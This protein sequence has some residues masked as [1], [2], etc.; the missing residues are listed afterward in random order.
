M[1]MKPIGPVVLY[2]P[3][4]PGL[5]T[6]RV[7][8]LD[9]P[10]SPR[11]EDKESRMRSLRYSVAVLA[12]VVVVGPGSRAA[13]YTPRDLLKFRP[14]QPS[15]DYDTPADAAA[16]DACKVELVTDGQKR[17]VGY[18]LRDGQGK[19]LRRFVI[20]SGGKYLNQWS[21]FQDGFEVYRE[22]DL[23]GDRSLDECRWLN[24]GG[25]RIAVIK[26]G[27]VVSWKRLSAEEASKVLV[28]ALVSGDAGLLESLMATADELAGAGVPKEVVEKLSAA[29]ARRGEM[30]DALHK[31][32][33][34]WTAKT[35]WNRF[36]GTFPHVIPAD[37][38]GGVEQDLVLYENAVIFA[39]APGGG[40]GAKTSFLQVPEMIKLGETWK[41]V[42]LPRAV[43]P[44]KPV[45][46]SAGGIRAAIFDAGGPSPA[47]D[48][49]MDKALKALADYDSA[50]AKFQAGDKKD[51][52]RFHVGRVP[53]LNAV[54]KVAKDPE[55]QHSYRK[56]IVDSLVA[57]YQTGNYP[58]AREVLDRMIEEKTRVSSYAAYRVIGAEF[59]M[60]NE[61]PGGNFL[62]NQK[63]WMADLEGFLTKFDKSD[64]AP[65]VW[66]QLGSSNEFNAE[67]D[68]A[69]ADYTKLV[70]N[71]PETPSGKKAAGALR[72]LDLVGKSV[73]IKGAGLQGEAIDTSQ[74]R[75]KPVLVVFWA[76]WGG[77]SVRR[78]IPDLVK[79]AEKNRGRNLEIIGVS[80]DNE[81]AELESFVKEQQVAW[82]Q[83]FE[84][85]GIDSRL[86]TEYGIISLPTIFLIDGQGKVLQRNLRTASEVERQLEKLATQ[87]PAGVALGDRE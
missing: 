79:L 66:L 84:P 21:Y 20:T 60:R 43:D 36:D 34:G 19:L 58:Q 39:G 26:N 78:E 18:A 5:A 85:G 42:E 70:D 77:Q 40:A 35:V 52:A 64:E 57:A 27:K 12:I 10:G 75:G 38:A 71:F 41:F 17:T 16:I 67:E 13:D 83:I 33:A 82:P 61:E 74:A 37:P 56:Q 76:S 81:K 29:A 30:L 14:T 86:A 48:E 59:V 87:K 49:A 8:G 65:E 50:G 24:G 3:N 22:N 9:N 28:Q 62:A 80:L 15:V 1:P 4:V 51:L 53:L 72:R 54:V 2:V 32:L 7:S 68:K 47:R 46:A 25:T 55:D 11:G 63:K 23:D 69:R 45:V 73:T 6:G 44:E 31:S